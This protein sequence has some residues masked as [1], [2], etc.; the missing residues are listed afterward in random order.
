MTDAPRQQDLGLRETGP[1]ENVEEYSFEPIKG[2]PML[3]WR[4]KRPFTSTVYYPAQ[5]RETYG[6]AVNGWRN[7]LYWGDNLQVMSHLVKEFRG[8]VQLVY[9]DPPFDSK[10]DY[11]RQIELR[12]RTA[13][14]DRTVFEEKQY[15]DIWTNDEYLQFMYE[16]LILIRELL[17][18]NGSLFVHCD[19]HKSH[20]LRCILDEIFG[21]GRFQ[22]EIVWY[23]YNKMQG[24]INRFAS[25]HDV[26]LW[27]SKGEKP[28]FHK[29]QEKREEATKQI[30][31]VWSKEKKKLVNAKDEDGHVLYID[32]THRTVDDVWRISMLQPAD[33]T[34]NLG[35]PTQKPESLVERIIAA[36]SNPGDIVFDNFMGSGTTQAVATRLGRKFLGADINLG[37][38]QM[39]TRRLLTLREN[40]KTANLPLG[41]VVEEDEQEFPTTFYTGFEVFNVNHYDVFRNPAEAKDLLLQA[42]EVNRLQ[43]GNLFDGEKD[44]RMVKVMPITRIATRQDLNELING[45]DYK[46]FERRKSEHPTRP[47]EKI[48]LI[49]MGHEPDLASQLRMEVRQNTSGADIDVEVMDILRDKQDLQFKRDSEARIVVQDGQ[50]IIERFYPMNLLSKL[51]METESMTD[52]RELVESIMID[53]NYDSA[54]LQ[55]TVLDIPDGNELVAGRYPIPDDAGTIR[56]KITDLLSESLEVEVRYG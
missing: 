33:Q 31:R 9:I 7:R 26:I 28:I 45:F 48:T 46:A 4:G 21:P 42:F 52:W 54:V 51:S 20:H 22:N 23:Y 34:E 16:R 6:E 40:L 49:C 14:N 3:H 8:A 17:T 13:S 53:W 25:N 19:W 27:Y 15:E 18:D 55:P 1:I 56:V 39:T 44:G 50:L 43:P 37:A 30:K 5:R 2:Y 29:I 12:G 32:A 36:A 24:N 35:Y 47:V 10:A 11:K 41:F 38:V